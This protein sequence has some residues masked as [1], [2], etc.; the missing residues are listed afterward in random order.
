MPDSTKM[1]EYLEALPSV[2]D[3]NLTEARE[4]EGR[5]ILSGAGDK[6]CVALLLQELLDITGKE[7]RVIHPAEIPGKIFSKANT[8]VFITQSGKTKDVLK[9]IEYLKGK[10]HE[11]IFAITNLKEPVAGSV[12][13]LLPSTNIFNTA[14]VHYPE[15]PLPSTET[16]IASVFLGASL[17]IGREK[18]A[19]PTRKIKSRIASKDLRSSGIK[20]AEKLLELLPAVYTG[21][22]P[23]YPVVRKSA[24]IMT[25]EGIKEAAFPLRA[26]EFLHSLIEVLESSRGGIPLVLFGFEEDSRIEKIM[27]MWK[28]PVLRYS[29][30]MPN[31]ALEK[32]LYTVIPAV[33]FMWTAYT[34]ALLLGKDPGAAKMVKKVRAEEPW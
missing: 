6:Y 3:A 33:E 5:L 11:K 13:S 25:M 20:K 22:A 12:Y 27:E 9:A 8:F 15:R 34:A 21:F 29:A 26:E 7:S 23:F 31:S 24:L 30:P 1:R 17:F 4:F 32:V 28:W 2:I 14:T 19:E 18:L 10:G 16:F